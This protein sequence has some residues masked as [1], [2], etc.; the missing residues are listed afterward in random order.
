MLFE[1][2]KVKLSERERQMRAMEREQ[3]VVLG[4][5]FRLLFLISIASVIVSFSSYVAA[6]CGAGFGVIAVISGIGL[7][8]SI[9]FAVNLFMLGKFNGEFTM[10][11]L[12]YVLAQIADFCRSISPVGVSSVFSIMAAALSV[13]YVIKFT[14]AMEACV[15]HADGYL[16]E[17][18]EKFRRYF[19]YVTIFTIACTVLIFVPSIVMVLSAIGIF[20]AA[21]ASLILSVWQLVLLYRSANTMTAFSQSVIDE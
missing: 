12:A 3:A 19:I 2:E 8:M 5:R 15:T 18:W 21:I 9:L 1:K 11:G 7:A 6:Y 4:R 20:L 17:S 13:G 14:T 16:A 10:A